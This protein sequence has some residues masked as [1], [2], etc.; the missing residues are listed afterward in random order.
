MVIM[1]PAVALQPLFSER[2]RSNCYPMCCQDTE[3]RSDTRVSNPELLVDQLR[4][5]IGHVSVCQK[6]P[7]IYWGDS[8]LTPDFTGAGTTAECQRLDAM[9]VVSG[10][11]SVSRF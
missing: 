6:A 5:E 2:T 3:S 9:I 8:R 10:E 7:K 11:T 4:G 1:R